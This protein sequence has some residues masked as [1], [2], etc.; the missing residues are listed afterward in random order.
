MSVGA[1]F[2]TIPSLANLLK[3]SVKG[4]VKGDEFERLDNHSAVQ[5]ADDSDLWRFDHN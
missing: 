3:P 5:D 4:R 1:Y 2:T